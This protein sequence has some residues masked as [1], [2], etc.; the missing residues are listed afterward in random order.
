METDDGIA[1]VTA[2]TRKTV[3]TAAAILRDAGFITE[4]RRPPHI[5]RANKMW[6]TI[7]SRASVIKLRN[8][9][10]G[11]E[12][13]GGKFVSWRLQTADDMPTPSLDDYIEAWMERDQL[14]AE[15]VEWMSSTPIIICPVGATTAY[16]H[17]TLKVSVED[18]TMGTFRAFSY[19]QAFNVFDLPVVTIPVGKSNDGLPI[20]IQVVGSPFAE[21]AILDVAEIIERAVEWKGLDVR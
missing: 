7:F 3:E 12:T 6:L 11:R 14:R 2:E 4:E 9:Y 8:V 16:K 13:E 10:K 21:E 5:E 18:K 17:G 15:L 20:G 1:P 19:S